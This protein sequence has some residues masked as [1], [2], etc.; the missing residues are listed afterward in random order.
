MLGEL[1]VA[2]S[3]A[4]LVSPRASACLTRRSRAK[5]LSAGRLRKKVPHRAAAVCARSHQASQAMANISRPSNYCSLAYSALAC[6]R[7]GMSG[8]ASF[9][10]VRKSW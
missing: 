8:S 10:R 4:P 9:Q 2:H 7:I 3:L 1:L 5:S 6:L